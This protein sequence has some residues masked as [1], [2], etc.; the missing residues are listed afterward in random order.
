MSKPLT[1]AEIN[2]RAKAYW[3]EMNQEFSSF[4]EQYPHYVESDRGGPEGL[5]SQPR[6]ISGRQPV[7]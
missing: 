6:F 5:D 7:V 1:P 4:C 3:D 2:Q